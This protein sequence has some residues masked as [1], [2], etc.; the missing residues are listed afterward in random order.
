MRRIYRNDTINNHSITVDESQSEPDQVIIRVHTID[1]LVV[2]NFSKEEFE[3]LCNLKFRLDF[4]SVTAQIPLAL[5][6]A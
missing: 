4:P 2:L 3:E 1:N 5:V 6:A